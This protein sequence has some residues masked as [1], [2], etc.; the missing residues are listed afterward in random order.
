LNLAHVVAHQLLK[1]LKG[2]VEFCIAGQVVPRKLHVLLGGLAASQENEGTLEPCLV[3]GLL[4][5][6]VFG[7]SLL[8]TGL[9]HNY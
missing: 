9:L 3:E 5:A 6:R 2:H 8:E 7:E 4:V 1:N